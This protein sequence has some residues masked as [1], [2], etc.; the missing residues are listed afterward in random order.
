M[1]RI[2]KSSRLYSSKGHFPTSALC[3]NSWTCPPALRRSSATPYY[4]PDEDRD[5]SQGH[6]TRGLQQ[7]SHLEIKVPR[8]LVEKCLA[9][10]LI[11]CTRAL[12][13]CRED[14]LGP[15]PDKTIHSFCS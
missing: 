1:L 7:C 12:G 3:R 11:R 6:E 9:S 4:W 5:D 10:D 13:D 15:Y 14:R 2:R 8:H